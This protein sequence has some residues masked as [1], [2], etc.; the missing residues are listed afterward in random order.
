MFIY[1]A[2]GYT[3]W[4]HRSEAMWWIYICIAFYLILKYDLD[5]PMFA[6]NKQNMQL[7]Q[8]EKLIFDG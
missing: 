1:S 2:Y 7:F 4:D 5:D 3:L 8:N 6:A